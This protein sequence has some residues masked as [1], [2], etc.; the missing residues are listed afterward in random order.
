MI[1]DSTVGIIVNALA[2]RNELKSLDFSRS[3]L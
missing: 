1:G 2:E 3:F